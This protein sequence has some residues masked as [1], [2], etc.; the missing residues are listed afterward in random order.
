MWEGSYGKEPFDLRLTV[1]RLVCNVN[2][3]FALTMVGTLLFGGGYY[4]KNVLLRPEPEYSV[5]ST[6]KVQYV[7]EPTKSGDYYINE[8]TWQALVQTKEFLG[9]VQAHL[10]E[11]A[12]AENVTR[13]ELSTE[14]LASVITAKLP[15][16]WHVPT[17]TVVTKD[18]TKTLL[19]AKAVEMAMVDELAEM[20]KQ[21]VSSVVVLDAAVA[22]TEVPLDVRPVRAF[23]L[24]AI[25]SLFFVTTVILLKETGDDSVWLPSTLRRRY[26][27]PVLGTIHSVELV[28]NIK[29]LF[30]QK[31]RVAV[32]AVDSEVNPTLVSEKLTEIVRGQ[33]PCVDGENKAEETVIPDWISVPTPLLCP[34]AC[35]T[36]REMD[37]ILLVVKAGS[38]AGK[39]L[40]YVL[41]LLRQQECKITAVILW[42][43][44]EKLLRAYYCLPDS[45]GVEI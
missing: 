23:V 26:G 3:I 36:L 20:M 25:L 5:T 40:E 35:D 15:S 42:E 11:A 43:A 16:D 38:H 8:A 1:L 21:E 13:P 24:S 10:E 27:L 33:E 17:T 39:P 29:Y 22:A 28:Q 14:E 30:G 2:K 44:D 45:R 31:Q 34:E 12:V 32:C 18:G 7:D 19:I 6:Y 37:G 4:V 41:E 9:G